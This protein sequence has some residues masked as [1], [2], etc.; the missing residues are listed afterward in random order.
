MKILIADK[1]SNAGISKLKDM[2]AEVT[3]NPDL[4]AEDLCKSL[5]D[6]EVLVVR[7][8]KVKEDAI[9]SAPALSLIIRAGAGFNTIDVKYASEHGISVSNC[10]GKNTDA[11]AELSIGHLIA[12]DRRIV[13]ACRDLGGGKW[14]KKA[15]QKA[16]GLKGRTLGIIG[17]GAIGKSVIK[18][19]KGLEMHVIA[20]SRSL[21]KERADEMEVGYCES[22]LDLAKKADA[23][24]IHIASKPETAHMI[25]KEFF[26]AMNDGAILI[27]ASR[28]EVID[29]VALKEAIKEKELRV[30]MD[31]Y[32]NEPATG[33]APFEDKELASMV[34]C[35]PHIGAST[36]QASEE[37]AAEVIKII[38]NYKEK[39]KPLNTVNIR[40]KTSAIINLV[41]R[42]YNKVGVLAGVLDILRGDNVNIEEME[43]TIFE[44]GKAAT[45]IIKLDSKPSVNAMKELADAKNIIQVALN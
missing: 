42:H 40:G 24:S 26:N 16:R 17:V 22:P 30:G 41:V 43:N 32:E 5:G 45:C 44:G 13:Y 1:M 2:G 33:E 15:Y 27:N 6:S 29:T 34:T 9:Q 28:G 31:V 25:N 7:S 12:A 4:K 11:V 8:T 19:A 18:K 38:K 39:G 10:P 37:V 35:T 36:D 20:W 14:R 23:V 3:Y 21:T